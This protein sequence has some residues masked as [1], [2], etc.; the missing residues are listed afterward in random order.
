M[1]VEVEVAQLLLMLLGWGK[2]AAGTA[3]AGAT[4]PLAPLVAVDAA[5]AEVAGGVWHVFV[6]PEA[7]VSL[8]DSFSLAPRRA[9]GSGC[10]QG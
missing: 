10:L 1:E 4:A 2:V 7:R 9:C 6:I 5:A 8:T 3:A